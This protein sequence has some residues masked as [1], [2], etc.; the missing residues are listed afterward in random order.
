MYS[1][2]FFFVINLLFPSLLFDMIHSYYTERDSK[3][4]FQ[5]GMNKFV[6]RLS[7]QYD[8]TQ[9][10]GYRIGDL[11]PKVLS[12]I[13]KAYHQRSDLILASW[14]EI[15]GAKLA[16]M[17]QAV[18]FTEGILFVKVKSSTLHS[19]LSQNDRL[20][21]LNLLRKK[22]PQTEIKNICFRIG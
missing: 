17:T 8:G 22:F 3:I 5:W 16:A 9:R 12:K 14:P 13:E 2:W 21:I 1:S 20:R 7:R 6:S 15:I 11:L 10:T 18:A 4:G 19:L